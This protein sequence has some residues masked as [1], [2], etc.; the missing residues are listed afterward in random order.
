MVENRQRSKLKALALV[1]SLLLNVVLASVLFYSWL[2]TRAERF[3]LD[4]RLDALKSFLGAWALPIVRIEFRIAEDNPGAGLKPVL[5]PKN[6]RKFYVHSEILLSNKDI[7]SVK[8]I[9]TEWG[10]HAVD[11]YFTKDGKEKFTNL[12]VENV[13]KRL[14][15]LANDRLLVAPYIMEPVKEDYVRIAGGLTKEEAKRI[16]ISLSRR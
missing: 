14:A 13:K 1:A 8:L 4:S 6:G 2:G 16:V 12:T 15:I 11:L 10:E 9:K 5:S 3:G 7:G